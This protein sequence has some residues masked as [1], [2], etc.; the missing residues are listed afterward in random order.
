M[1]LTPPLLACIAAYQ[2]PRPRHS[3][4][5]SKALIAYLHFRQPIS[6]GWARYS[7]RLKNKVL[8][9]E[10]RGYRRPHRLPFDPHD[11]DTLRYWSKDFDRLP[12]LE[13]M[14]QEVKANKWRARI[15]SGWEGWDMEIYGSRYVKV[16]ITTATEHHHGV[17]KLT[18]VRVQPLM[19]NF[20]KVLLIAST[21]LAALL[22]LQDYL[23][24]FSRTAVLIPLTWWTMYLINRWRVTTPVLG[25][26]DQ[27]AE[28]AGY[29]PVPA[30]KAAK[31]KKVKK[32]KPAKPAAAAA[33]PA[34]QSPADDV[35]LEEHVLA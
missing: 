12:V 11:R 22:L 24:P 21:I 25:M 26:I 33:K 19:S 20:C 1:F 27:V 32:A 5:L 31:A 30:K 18:R 23:W 28:E 14:K 34:A 6:R 3:H 8:N 15:D 13:R 17:G 7:V 10:A 35:D 2:A 4:W 29:W 16:R 9:T